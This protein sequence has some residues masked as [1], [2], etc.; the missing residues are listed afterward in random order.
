[1]RNL[2]FIHFQSPFVLLNCY[3]DFFPSLLV[4]YVIRELH[5]FKV[6]KPHNG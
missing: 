6:D 1:M 3:Y 2:S 4:L 5:G